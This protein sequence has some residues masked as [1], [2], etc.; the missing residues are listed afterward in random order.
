MTANRKSVRKPKTESGKRKAMRLAETT[1]VSPKQ[2][3]DLMREHGKDSEKVDKE[4]RN[5]KAEG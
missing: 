1:D 4:A 5:F 3:R 2:A